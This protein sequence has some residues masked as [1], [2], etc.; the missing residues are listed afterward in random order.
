MITES[1][2]INNRLH[3]HNEIMF[4]YDKRIALHYDNGFALLTKKDHIMI[5][6]YTTNGINLQ[7][8][9]YCW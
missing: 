9:N 3:D 6:V 4:H 2:Y 1:N 7:I 8:L 5:L